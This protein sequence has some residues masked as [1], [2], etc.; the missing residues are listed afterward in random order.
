MAFPMMSG[1][2]LSQLR[3]DLEAHTLPDSCVI[4]AVTHASDGAGGTNDTW[5]PSGTVACRLD[6]KSGMRKQVGTSW[7]T[8]SGWML[9]VPQATAITTSNRVAHQGKTYSVTSVEDLGSWLACKRVQV[10]RL[11]T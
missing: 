2:E 3:A 9:T 5:A 8:Y 6:H 7:E 10:E 4:S 11:W 1:A